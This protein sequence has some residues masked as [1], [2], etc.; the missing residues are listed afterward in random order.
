MI[1][2]ELDVSDDHEG[3]SEPWW[4]IIDPNQQMFELDVHTVAN[5]VTGP[6]FSRESAQ[7]FLDATRYNF[8]KHAKV[9]C[10]SGYHSFEYRQAMKRGSIVAH[11]KSRA[12]RS[13]F[14]SKMLLLSEQQLRGHVLKAVLKH[15]KEQKV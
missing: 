5:M 12:V 6:F 7:S 13:S 10:H 14:Y 2:I 15:R 9:Y 4:L 1:K 3:T 8:S 11:L